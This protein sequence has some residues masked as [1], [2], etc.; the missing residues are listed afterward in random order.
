VGQHD[1]PELVPQ[2]AICWLDRD[3]QGSPIQLTVLPSFIEGA[4]AR[5]LLNSYTLQAG[6]PQHAAL[7]FQVIAMPQTWHKA[8]FIAK[9]DMNFDLHTVARTHA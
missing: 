3:I 4:S 6:E 7:F 5:M 1:A 9:S 2:H 8:M